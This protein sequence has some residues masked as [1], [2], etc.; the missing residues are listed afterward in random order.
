MN[1][2]K[3]RKKRRACISPEAT[4][5]SD[6]DAD[7]ATHFQKGQKGTVLIV[8]FWVFYYKTEPETQVSGRRVGCEVC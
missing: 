6:S 8:T 5:T 1:R 7:P 4:L 2:Q 3:D